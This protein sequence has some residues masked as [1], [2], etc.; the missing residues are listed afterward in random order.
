MALKITGEHISDDGKNKCIHYSDGGIVIEPIEDFT[1]KTDKSDKQ[2]ISLLIVLLG[3]LRDT[4]YVNAEDR[5]AIDMVVNIA[6]NVY[7]ELKK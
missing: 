2:K 3:E 4:D 5:T 6:E 1:D 7:N